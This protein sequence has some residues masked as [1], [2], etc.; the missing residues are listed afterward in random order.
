MLN[1][2]R[3]KQVNDRYGHEEGDWMIETLGRLLREQ[4][5]PA[6]LAYRCS[7]EEFVVILPRAPICRANSRGGLPVRVS[8]PLSAARPPGTLSAGVANFPTHGTTP[9][10][11]LRAADE[12]LYAAKLARQNCVCVLSQ[13]DARA[14]IGE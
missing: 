13:G 6:D 3:F 9:D 12:A 7:G 11:L 2:D 1:I 8:R 4:A 14:T 10:N 5:R